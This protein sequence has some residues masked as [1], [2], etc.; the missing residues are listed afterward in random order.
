MQAVVSEQAEFVYPSS[1]C[2][3]SSFLHFDLGGIKKFTSKKYMEHFI[4][5]SL[6]TIY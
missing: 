5:Q 1:Y 2:T 3:F 4:F 6:S